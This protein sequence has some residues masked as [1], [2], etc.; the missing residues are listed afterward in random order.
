M[1]L[2]EIVIDFCVISEDW[3]GLKLVVI[4]DVIGVMTV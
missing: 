4:D 1:E 3:Y 2:D